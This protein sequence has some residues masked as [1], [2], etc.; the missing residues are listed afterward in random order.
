MRRRHR[1]LA[2]RIGDG[3]STFDDNF[4][5]NL[6]IYLEALEAAGRA[7]ADQRVYVGFQGDW[8]GTADIGETEWIREPRAAWQ[9]W[10]EI[11]ADGAI[12]LARSTSDIDALVQA[13]ERW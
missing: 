10:H 8:L 5:K 6:P 9:R 3:W 12:V 13:V 7:R 1:R 11:G 4:E 2:A